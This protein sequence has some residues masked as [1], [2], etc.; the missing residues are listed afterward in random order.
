VPLI[1]YAK[2]QSMMIES[3][4]FGL[5]PPVPLLGL[6]GWGEGAEHAESLT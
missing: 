4:R 3:K 6:E 5:Q 1:V 2:A